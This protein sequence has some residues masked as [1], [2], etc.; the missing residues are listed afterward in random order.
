MVV[1]FVGC[2]LCLKPDDVSSN[3]WAACPDSQTLRHCDSQLSL[4]VCCILLQEFLH[5]CYYCFKGYTFVMGI[6]T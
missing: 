4:L 5:V 6:V 1:P 2:S 3:L